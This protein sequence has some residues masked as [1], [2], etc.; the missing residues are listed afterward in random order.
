MKYTQL[1]K[2][3]VKILYLLFVISVVVFFFIRLLP[4]SP[5]ETYLRSTGVP[6]TA[7]N[8]T[9]LRAEWEL[10]RP[11]IEQYLKWIG[12]FIKFNWGTSLITKND[13]KTEMLVRLPYSLGIGLGGVLISAF[14]SFF[15][16]Y[17]SSLKRNGFFDRFTRGLSLMSQIVP[18]FILAI[19]IIY[20]FSIKWKI[21]TFFF[22][23]DLSNF[24]LSIFIIS[25]YLMGK[26]SRI[27]RI[28]FRE[29]MTKTYILAA[30]SRGFSEK[31]VLFGHAARPVIYGLIS[32]VIS[33]FSWVIGGTAVLEVIFIIP[34]IS[35]FLVE[36]IKYR[37]YNVIQSYIL[38]VVIWMIAVKIFFNIILKYLDIKE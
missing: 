17:F 35:T 32:A 7:E 33:E 12:N 2:E 14:L 10:D 19:I 4:S 15:L 30:I 36:S 26:F 21:T 37:D 29:Q 24:F 38:I 23:K 20:F 18:S 3:T 11:L 6:V 8:L 25:L 13:I 1:L 5:E 9:N 27:V 31:Y 22:N 34:G 28:H 16:G